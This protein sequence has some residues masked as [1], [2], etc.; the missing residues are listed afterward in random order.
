[1]NW[2]IGCCS[3]LVAILFQAHAAGA[4]GVDC[5]GAPYAARKVDASQYEMPNPPE[6][7][8]DS[9]AL[10]SVS[11]ADRIQR[12]DKQLASLPPEL[13]R[14]RRGALE[15][16][17]GAFINDGLSGYSGIDLDR[18]LAVNIERRTRAARAAAPLAIAALSFA[19]YDPTT[20]ARAFSSEQFEQME[21]VS[22]RRLD[23]AQLAAFVC[24]ANEVWKIAPKPTQVPRMMPTDM[25]GASNLL[26]DQA[27]VRGKWFT[28]EKSF[29]RGGPLSV[30]L[31]Q[32]APVR[33][34]KWPMR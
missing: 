29:E 26:R 16:W 8:R 17:L 27:T 12:Q 18:K 2:G 28:F 6:V 15:W 23:D 24:I 11:N 32:A 30:V 10:P 5:F 33:T 20:F 25:L 3:L 14:I 4:D 21:V 13:S 1:M 9:G 31:E 7:I 22:T 19:E 34:Y